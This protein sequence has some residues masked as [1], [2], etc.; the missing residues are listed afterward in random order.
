MM[1]LYM[2]RLKNGRFR[3]FISLNFLIDK[4]FLT[5]SFA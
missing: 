4:L 5:C 1:R 2:I 3:A